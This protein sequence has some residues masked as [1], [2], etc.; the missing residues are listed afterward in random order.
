MSAKQIA[1]S[2]YDAELDDAARKRIKQL[3]SLD[4]TIYDA[5]VSHFKAKKKQFL[6]AEIES[7][8]AALRKVNDAISFLCNGSNKH[9]CKELTGLLNCLYARN[10]DSRNL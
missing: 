2:L 4:Q 10:N 1:L 6:Q 9:R 8:V 3:T 7:E 5:A